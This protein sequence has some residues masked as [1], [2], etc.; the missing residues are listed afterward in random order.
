VT[1]APTAPNVTSSIRQSHNVKAISGQQLSL[2]TKTEQTFYQQAR[3]KYLAE[4]QFTAA[5]DMRALDRLLLLEVQVFRWQW[6]LAAGVNYELEFLEPREEAAL[7]K[8]LK[9]TG[10]MISALQNDLGLTKNQREK[11]KHDSV[12]AYLTQLKISA[13]AFGVM[14]EKQLGKAI[15]L[16]KELFNVAGAYKRSNDKERA[17]L[18]FESAEDVV[19]WVLEVMKPQFDEVDEHF[20]QNDQRFWLRKVIA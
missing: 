9:E 18:G 11:D 6:Q 16:T 14:R 15:E 13:K 20:R 19:D 1:T 5:S 8:A 12:G 4:N 3:D 2:Q 17:K 7:Q 10:P